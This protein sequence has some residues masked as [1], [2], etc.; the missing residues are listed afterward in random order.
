MA[1]KP[2]NKMIGLFMAVGIGVFAL[3]LLISL[4]N[5][6]FQNNK[7]IIVMYFDESL[8][9]LSVGSSVMFKGVEVGQVSRIELVANTKDLSFRIPVYVEFNPDQRIISRDKTIRGKQELLSELIKKGLRARLGVQNY[10]TGQ[11]FIELAMLPDTPLILKYEASDGD[12]MEIPTVLSP[13]GMISKD[14]S[15]LPIKQAVDNING[16]FA[17]LNKDLPVLMPK[18]IDTAATTNAIL[19]ENRRVTNEM[20]KNLNQAA[21]NISNAAQSFGN[22]SDYIE[23]H[24]DALLKGKKQ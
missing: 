23:R 13:M 5:V 24:P 11:L 8:R 3:I 6:I 9:G 1:K 17:T 7:N 18:L 21:K 2:N 20:I 12:Y 10:I 4:R 15:K 19:Q 16:T 22:L 14:F